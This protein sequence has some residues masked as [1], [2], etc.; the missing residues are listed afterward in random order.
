MERIEIAEVRFQV[1]F[2]GRPTPDVP[3]I[4]ELARWCRL[5]HDKGLTPSYGKGTSGNLSV[6]MGSEK[7]ELLITA[8]GLP[9]KESLNRTDFV[10]VHSVNRTDFSV[11]AS[12]DKKP[13]SETALHQAIYEKRPDIN[14]VFH[15]HCG[16]ILDS[17]AALKL[18]ET[19]REEQYGSL[20]LVNHVIE[21]MGQEKFIVMKNHGFLSLGATMEEAGQIALAVHAQTLALKEPK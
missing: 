15:G 3:E 14:A 11:V 6:R 9:A 2:T 5:F 10:W 17:A 8:S 13:S 18:F 12:G 21:V 20:A 7:N 16:E 1:A 4:A 19:P